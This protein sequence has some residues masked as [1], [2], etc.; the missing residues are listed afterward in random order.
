MTRTATVF[1]DGEILK[2]SSPLDLHPNRSYVIRI[3]D[4]DPLPAD[5]EDTSEEIL[6]ARENPHPESEQ[7]AELGFEDWATL[8]PEE[9]IS[10]LVEAHAGTEVRWVPGEGWREI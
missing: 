5:L 3:G 2:P 4:E 8:L 1:F 6:R 7:W 9:D 10:E